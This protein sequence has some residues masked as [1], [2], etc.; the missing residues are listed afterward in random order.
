LEPGECPPQESDCMTRFRLRQIPSTARWLCL[1]L[2]L[3][4]LSGASVSLAQGNQTVSPI[5]Q[6]VAAGPWQMTI[7]QVLTGGD[8]GAAAAGASASNPDPAEGLQYV[9]AQVNVQNSS[10]QPFMIGPGDFAVVGSSGIVRRSAGVAAPSP[11]LDGI[12]QPGE[13]ADGWVLLSTEADAENLVLI[14]DSAT[15]TGIW[16]DHI[17]AISDGATFSP[18]TT[19][20]TEIDKDGQ[21]PEKPVGVGR[22]IATSEW[23]IKIVDVVQGAAVIDIAPEET[24]RLGQS[25]NSGDGTYAS[26]LD[27]WIAI[28]IEATNNGDD[29]LTRFLSPTAFQLADT[30]GS[31]LNDIRTLSPPVPDLSGE[32]AAGAS[33]AG[34]ISFELPSSC[35]PDGANISYDADL[36]RFQ[37]F[38]TSGD[39]RYLTWTGGDGPEPVD[40]PTPKPFDSSAALQ[41]GSTA[42]T[43]DDGV[44]MRSD[45]SVDGKIVDE[46]D[47]GTEVEI[48][49]APEEGDGFTWYPVRNLKN[50]DEGW[51][52]QDFLAAP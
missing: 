50:D 47:K 38:A 13:S 2:V 6:A 18:S 9:A 49:G 22:V 11:E 26:C 8:A 14:Y 4:L 27:T 37:P 41:E 20:A 16:A 43:T 40:T 39:V 25:Y 45:P 10:G 46:L 1:A 17:F 5:G 21:S 44:R 29:G 35:G 24:K 33:R 19:R 12:V 34:W 51:I 32:Y 3:V 23:R 28:Q 7:E 36:L 52:V 30:D 42:V 31:A 15:I 48:T